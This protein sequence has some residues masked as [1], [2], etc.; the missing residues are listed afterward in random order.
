VTEEAEQPAILSFDF[1]H[2][3]PHKTWVSG[4]SGAAE[5]DQDA[6]RYK[7][8]SARHADNDVYELMIVLQNADG[9]KQVLKHLTLH[10]GVERTARGFVDGLSREYDI[11]FE[12]QDFS[13]CHSLEEFEGVARR[14]GWRISE[15]DGQE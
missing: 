11:D 5:D 15:P 3:F 4:W 2:V 10:G 12:E 13:A 1:V 7:V 14:F 9:S 6:F 8:M